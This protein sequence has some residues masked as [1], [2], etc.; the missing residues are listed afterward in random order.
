MAKKKEATFSF[1]TAYQELEEILASL[2]S[3]DSLDGIE[4]K[5]KKAKELIVAC[6]N[7]LRDLDTLVD[8]TINPE[9]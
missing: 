1:D 7:K 4:A 9:A 8:E 3:D 5:I 2:Q 6:K